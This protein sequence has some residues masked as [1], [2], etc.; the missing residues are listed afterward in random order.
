MTIQE[1]LEMIIGKREE[2]GGMSS[3]MEWDKMRNKLMALVEKYGPEVLN[4]T[5]SKVQNDMVGVTASGKRAVWYG[6]NGMETRSR[7]CGTLMIDGKKVF[8][9]GT[10][11]KAIEYLATR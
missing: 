2:A 7:Y 4:Y 3:R 5:F 11:S 6:N 8:T 1:K 9:S 10:V